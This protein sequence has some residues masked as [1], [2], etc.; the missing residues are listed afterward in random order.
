VG[1]AASVTADLAVCP[2]CD[3]D[4]G[5]RYVALLKLDPVRVYLRRS[6]DGRVAFEQILVLPDPSRGLATWALVRRWDE[7][8]RYDL[9]YRANK[10][11]ELWVTRFLE[12]DEIATPRQMTRLVVSETGKWLDENAGQVAPEVAQKLV[13]SVKDAAQADYLDLEELAERVIPNSVLRDEYLGRMLDKGLTETRFEPD[14]QWAERQSLKT[15]Y[16]LDDGVTIAGPSD[17]IDSIVQV[18]PKTGDGKTRIV[19]ETRRFLQK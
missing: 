19:I 14:R 7:E 13:K 5:E 6:D 9:L 18:L 10:G 8:A 2:F 17:V 15:T 4:S 12:C 1:G 16:L 11:D 3:P